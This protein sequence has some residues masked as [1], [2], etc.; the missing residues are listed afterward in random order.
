[1]KL[2]N[3]KTLALVLVASIATNTFTMDTS[4][5]GTFTGYAQTALHACRSAYEVATLENAKLVY[6][7]TKEALEAHPYVTGG[8]LATALIAGGSY[9]VYKLREAAQE[10]ARMAQYLQ[11]VAAEKAAKAE[12]EAKAL[13]ASSSS[14]SS[15][16]SVG[17]MSDEE[18]AAFDKQR[19]AEL[20][21]LL[22]EDEV[23]N[24][25]TNARSIL[26]EP[27]IK[28][29]LKDGL[30]NTLDKDMQ[31]L[32]AFVNHNPELLDQAFFFTCQL[33]KIEVPET[34]MLCLQVRELQKRF[35][36]AYE[37]A[38]SASDMTDAE[39]VAAEIIDLLK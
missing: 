13:Q 19:N 27:V 5:W 6:Q 29:T 9:A 18:F 4:Y 7:T 35:K 15:T 25:E 3:K 34:D 14:T 10:K 31:A 28:L 32:D 23:E 30:L 24:R 39:L 16:K 37:K 1:M 17:E 22:N 33:A 21:A 38:M 11:N 20:A 26:F 36:T 8:T 2:I 12:Q